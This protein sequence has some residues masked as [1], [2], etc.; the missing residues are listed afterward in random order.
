MSSANQKRSKPYQNHG[1]A[2]QFRNTMKSGRTGSPYTPR[3]P[4]WR[5][6]YMPMAYPPSEKNAAWPRL[7]MPQYPQ[8]RSTASASMA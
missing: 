6:R 7:R 1:S 8:I 2:F 4:I 5:I 3:G